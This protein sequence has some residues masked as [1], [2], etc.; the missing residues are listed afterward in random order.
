LCNIFSVVV[1]N[2]HMHIKLINS[3]GNWPIVSGSTFLLP[4]FNVL[5]RLFLLGEYRA[6]VPRMLLSSDH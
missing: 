4:R 2:F 5:V 1:H 3:I 6:I